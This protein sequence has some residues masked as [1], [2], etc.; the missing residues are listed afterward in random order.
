[1][2]TRMLRHAQPAPQRS[3]GRRYGAA[4]EIDCWGRGEAPRAC[5]L[6]SGRARLGE[7]REQPGHD[8]PSLTTTSSR[9]A[10]KLLFLL[11][12]VGETRVRSVIAIR[13]AARS[14]RGQRRHRRCAASPVPQVPPGVGACGEVSSRRCPR[15]RRRWALEEPAPCGSGPA[16]YGSGYTPARPAQPAQRLTP[17]HRRRLP[18]RHK[19]STPCANPR[20][21]AAS[22]S[23]RT[24]ASNNT[25]GARHRRR[26]QPEPE[27]RAARV[28]QHVTRRRA[29]PVPARPRSR[30]RTDHAPSD[31]PTRTTSSRSSSGAACR[32][33]RPQ[34]HVVRTLE[35]ISH[36]NKPWVP[37]RVATDP[38]PTR[39]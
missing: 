22:G 32:R 26:R 20:R 37:K 2:F 35:Y 4:V 14:R 5:A 33:L 25:L 39:F 17:D 36:S 13:S 15:L 31:K 7:Q 29:R 34:H 18:D 27:R 10:G 23:G 30:Q 1:M 6:R 21:H 3:Q 19:L 11:L 9:T 16:P 8:L 28:E 38:D 24:A 12:H